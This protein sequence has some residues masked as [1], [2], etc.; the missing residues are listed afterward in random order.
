M[1]IQYFEESA[2]HQKVIR[3][4]EKKSLITILCRLHKVK[5]K[6]SEVDVTLMALCVPF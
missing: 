3:H 5:V 2:F 4:T 1:E 6:I